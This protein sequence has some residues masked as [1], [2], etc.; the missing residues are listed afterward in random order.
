VLLIIEWVCVTNNRNNHLKYNVD[1]K[2]FIIKTG[3]SLHIRLVVDFSMCF[4]RITEMHSFFRCDTVNSEVS[5]QVYRDFKGILASLFNEN[6]TLGKRFF[7]LFYF[8]K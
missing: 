3:H 5:T 4:K 2:R 6:T 1:I 7:I 8:Q